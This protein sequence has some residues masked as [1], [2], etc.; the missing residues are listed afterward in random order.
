M[1]RTIVF[2]TGTRA[3]YGKI[4]PLIRA[5]EEETD[6]A[7]VIFATGMHTLD[8]Y[9][10]TIDE[11]RKNDHRRV[12]MYTNQVLEE[13]MDQILGNTIGGFS[14]FV[15]DVKPDL[16]VIHGDRLEALAG[17]SVGALAGITVAHIEGGEVSGTVDE[18]IRHAV[19]K[20][21]HLHL[22]ANSE[23]AL[24]LRQ[25]GEEEERIH[26]I[27]SP[28]IDVMLSS[29]LPSL[30]EVRHRYEIPFDHYA[31]GIFH[32][33][34]TELGSLAKQVEA[35]IEALVASKKNYVL[36]YPNND[37]GSSVIFDRLIGLISSQGFKLYPSLRFEYFLTLL[38]NAQF[39]IGNSSVGVR[40]APVYGV[41][42]VDIGSR[43]R[44]RGTAASILKCKPERDS[45]DAAIIQVSR[46]GRCPPSLSNGSGHSRDSFLNLLRREVPW[47]VSLQKHFQPYQPDSGQ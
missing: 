16:I 46:M 35:Y 4:K 28:E 7:C 31:I 6:H 43:Q 39:I 27:G 25:L 20:L 11:I 13:T 3:D 26:I 8:R 41:P 45:I 1:K 42:S 34:T 44:H 29:D 9:G 24:R 33:V 12:H 47:H 10:F 32:P 23:A 38:R 15:H 37:V 17:A 19:S 5:V 2:V 14:R 21:S 22:V 36:I 30:D 18:S 40:E